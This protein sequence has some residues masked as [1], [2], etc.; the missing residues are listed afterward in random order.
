MEEKKLSDEEELKQ[1]IATQ[2][3]HA[4]VSQYHNSLSEQ[5]KEK[6]YKLQAKIEFIKNKKNK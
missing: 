1:V 6:A 4:T 5:L 2:N 3:F